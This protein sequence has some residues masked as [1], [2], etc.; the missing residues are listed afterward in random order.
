MMT[1]LPISLTIAAGAALLNIWLAMR[2]GRV[3]TKEKVFVGDGGSEP[4]IRRMRAHANYVENTA[5]VLILIALVELGLGS[6]IWLWG[7]GAL[8][9]VGR[10]LHALGMDGMG[11]GRMAGTII[12]LLT[13]LGLAITALAAVYMTPVST[14]ATLVQDS[15]EVAPE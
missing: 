7:A 10:I 8:Y 9:L 4:V 12:T 13:Q 6:S 15:S 5:F 1:M 3:R 14:T 2:V 11:W